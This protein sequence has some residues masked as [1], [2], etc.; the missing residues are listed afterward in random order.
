MRA[1]IFALISTLVLGSISPGALTNS[2]RRPR[3]GLAMRTI[4]GL[5]AEKNLTFTTAATAERTS[6]VTMT[7]VITIR[8]FFTLSP[9]FLNK[10]AS[11]HA[12]RGG[13]YSNRRPSREFLA[14]PHQDA[15]L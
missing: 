15:L 13:R 12:L 7:V 6:K 5:R 2:T 11:M 3:V 14:L 9:F 1:E 10:R 8:D 4:V